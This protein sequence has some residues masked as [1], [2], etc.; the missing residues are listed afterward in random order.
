[1]AASN[2]APA[3]VSRQT[4]RLR[5]AVKELNDKPL[6]FVRNLELTVEE[7]LNKLS[8]VLIGPENSNYAGGHFPFV[9]RFPP[10][11]PLT[12][13]EFHFVPPMIHPNVSSQDGLTCHDQLLAEWAPKITL[14]RLLTEMHALLATPNYDTPIEGDS[15]VDKSPDRARQ[16]TLLF[17]P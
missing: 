7:N 3:P 8:G 11:Y 14:T 15:S 12:P 5:E 2:S 9:V 16:S 10:E 13:P 4:L 1:M 17:I 6:P